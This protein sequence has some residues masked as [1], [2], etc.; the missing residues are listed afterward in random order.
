MS[1]TI[2]GLPV[3]SGAPSSAQ[4][5]QHSQT[6]EGPL[7]APYC[8]AASEPGG[9]ALPVNPKAPGINQGTAAPAA[10]ATATASSTADLTAEA[11]SEG[12]LD[13]ALDRAPKGP[14]S[15]SSLEQQDPGPPPTRAFSLAA[16]LLAVPLGFLELSCLLRC[17]LVSKSV[18]LRD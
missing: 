3:P 12:L 18:Q 10:T 5:S 17:L 14:P 9:G 16:N 1:L 6:M 13:E 2:G 11:P 4:E 7:G 8:S 15:N